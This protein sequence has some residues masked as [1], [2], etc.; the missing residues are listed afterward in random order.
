MLLK[1]T[2]NRACEQFCRNSWHR[3]Y[4]KVVTRSY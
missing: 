3:F 2:R 1:L 4:S